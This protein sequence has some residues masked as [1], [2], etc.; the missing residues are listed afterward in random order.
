[1]QSRRTEPPVQHVV[2]VGGGAAGWM[3][4]LLLSTS[5]FGARLKVTVLESPTAADL[6]VGEGSTPGLRGF[7]DSLDIDEAEWMPACNATYKTG[8]AFDGWS[9]RPG[10]ENWFH[11]F[12]SMLDTLTMPT[13]LRNVHAR[14]DGADVHAHPDR[15]FVSRRVAIEG[16][17]PRPVHEFP[18]EIGYGYHLDPT[19]LGAF[20]RAKALQRGVAHV[21]RPMRSA[22]LDERGDIRAL[23]LDDG[24]SLAADFFVD[25]SGS[26]SLLIGEALK[27]PWVS[28]AD[29]LVNDAA[30]TF[31]TPH[32][33]GPLMSQTVATALGHGWAWK[34]P[35]ATHGGS[36]YVYSSAHLSAD[37]AE[38][39]LRAH[40]GLLDADVPMRHLKMRMGRHA[41]HWNRNCVAIGAAQGFIDPLEATALQSAQRAAASLVD[42]LERGDVGAGARASFNDGLNA[43]ADGERD[44]VVTHYKSNSRVDTDYWRANA[45]NDALSEPLQR[46]LHTWLSAQPIEPGIE[47]GSFGIGHATLSWYC[48][49]AGVGVFPEVRQTA[50]NRAGADLSGIDD[51]VRRST[52]NFPDHRAWLRDMPPHAE[53]ITLRRQP[54]DAGRRATLGAL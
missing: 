36:G 9:T 27:T 7:F 40:L 34:I 21:A 4:A 26:A 47:N 38:T 13:F 41:Q 45:A 12:P 3:T 8:V 54:A 43:R 32:G 51:L 50:A 23:E 49:L 33:D 29:G 48:L 42:V 35:L 31:S 10:H 44:F 53:R 37:A 1:M 17:A 24:D 2:V 22:T 16:R 52:S 15:F 6:G 18:F 46:L 5:T 25:C 20:L 14:L 30:I 39:E 11:P 28:F 19:L